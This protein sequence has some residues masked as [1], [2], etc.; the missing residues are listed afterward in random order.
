MVIAEP[1]S[2]SPPKRKIGLYLYVILFL[3]ITC[4]ATVTLSIRGY[5]PF[6]MFQ[7]TYLRFIVNSSRRMHRKDPDIV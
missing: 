5:I 3:I 6:A 4:A 7:L 1:E 2:D